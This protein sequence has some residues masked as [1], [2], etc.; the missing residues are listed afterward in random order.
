MRLEIVCTDEL[1]R[2]G[3]DHRQGE[4]GGQCQ[5]GSNV[6]LFLGM[7]G[8]LYFDVV[9]LIE[10]C[11]PFAGIDFGLLCVTRQQRAADITQMRS[12]QSDQP[13]SAM[14]M[15]PLA[16]QLGASAILVLQIGARQ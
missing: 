16:T 6:R 5:R 10:Q 11:R 2:M 4:L 14:A 7:A 1:H 13:R 12:R 8:T 15:E 3:G 9:T